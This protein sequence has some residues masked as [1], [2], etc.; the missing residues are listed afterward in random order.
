[1][2]LL[3]MPGL[4]VAETATDDQLNPPRLYGDGIDFDV[5]RDGEKIGHHGIHRP[6]LI[7]LRYARTTAAAHVETHATKFGCKHR[8]PVGPDVHVDA[9]T[10]ME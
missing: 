4:A 5:I 1:M 2:V 3:V 9:D 7:R 10:M 8:Q 6:L